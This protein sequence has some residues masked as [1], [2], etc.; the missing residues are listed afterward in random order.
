ML[1]RVIVEQRLSDLELALDRQEELILSQRNVLK[2]L[3]ELIFLEYQKNDGLSSSSATMASSSIVPVSQPAAVSQPA[4]VSSTTSQP[5]SSQ[6]LRPFTSTGS[7]PPRAVYRPVST[8]KP[9]SNSNSG[10]ID[11]EESLNNSGDSPSD[12]FEPSKK[13]QKNSNS[14]NV[15]SLI[16]ST[17]SSLPRKVPTPV[18]F[19]YTRDPTSLSSI[20][21]I[22]LAR[23]KR[24]LEKVYLI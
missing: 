6:P 16:Q 9:V 23:R 1:S 8:S 7:L 21:K 10:V 12:Y 24:S 5:V 22:Y 20:P 14:S 17:D 18:P 15:V 4:P 19:P 2:S 3:R 13:K 11:L